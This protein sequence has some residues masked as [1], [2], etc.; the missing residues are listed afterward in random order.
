MTSFDKSC[1]A[2]RMILARITSWYGDAYFR[3]RDSSSRRSSFVRIT[4]FGLD[5][6]IGEHLFEEASLATK[7]DMLLSAPLRRNANPNIL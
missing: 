4:G 1:A 6:G 5:S 7:Y 2:R 3:A